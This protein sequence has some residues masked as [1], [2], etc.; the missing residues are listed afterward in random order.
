MEKHLGPCLKM[1]H[2]RIGSEVSLITLSI[3]IT[4]SKKL[5]KMVL[6]TFEKPLTFVKFVKLVHHSA[7]RQ[8]LTMKIELL[9]VGW[10]CWP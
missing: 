1:V 9:E 10:H 4:G 8:T 7:L 6:E 2:E 3:F 5:H